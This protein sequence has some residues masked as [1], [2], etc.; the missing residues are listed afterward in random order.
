MSRAFHPPAPP[1]ERVV[2][3]VLP[4]M[5]EGGVEQN[6]LDMALYLKAQGWRPVVASSG[7]AKVALLEAAGIPHV[8]L[9]LRAKAPWALL[10]NAWRLR[11]VMAT[12][13]VEL[14]HARSR[15]PAW[16]AW[17]ACRLC[18]VP[19][20]TTFHGTYGLAGGWLKRFYNS[21]MVRGEVVMANS[22]YTANHI[23]ENY[24]V[25]KRRVVAIPRGVDV[26]LFDPALFSKADARAVREEFHIEEGVP[27]LVMVGRVTRWKGQD[28]LLR[29]MARLKTLR[30]HL[31][32]VGGVEK[33]SGYGAEVERLCEDLGL[34]ERVTLAGSRTD[35]PR[36]LNAADLALSCSVLPEAFGRASVEA[37]AMGVPM[38]ATALGG[39]LE[40]V[41]PGKTGWLVT[42]DKNGDITPHALAKTMN[43]ALRNPRLLARMGSAA[44]ARVMAHFTAQR[45]CAGEMAV[46]Q[47]VLARKRPK[48]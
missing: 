33:K 30:W 39:S 46:Y 40:T 47:R 48:T 26:S 13:R 45:C 17:A 3:Q 36:L 18:G 34:R 28:L 27:L 29:A 24:K 19:F 43:E 14:V 1:A 7:G 41:L 9:P 35:I 32:L 12:Y 15:A 23:I 6:T 8:T 25:E 5:A 44:K 37:M 4:A 16:S 2:L 20:V 38:V 21:V 10:A 22:H 11:R 31:L 42:A